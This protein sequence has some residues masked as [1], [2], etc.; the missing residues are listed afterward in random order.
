MEDRYD[1]E[2]VWVF[3]HQAVIMGFRLVLEGLGEREILDLDARSP[4][5]NCSMTSYLRGPE[6]A[7]ELE[8]VRRPD[9]GRGK[10]HPDDPRGRERRQ[11]ADGAL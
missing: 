1:G 2:R 6:G 3:S 10:L 4:M 5:A 9:R 8:A 11:E 7:L